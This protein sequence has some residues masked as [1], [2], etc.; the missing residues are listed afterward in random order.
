MRRDKPAPAACAAPVA[1]AERRPRVRRRIAAGPPGRCAHAACDAGDRGEAMNRLR[2]H[3]APLAPTRSSTLNLPPVR[4]GLLTKLNL[5]TVGLIF[6]TAVAIT[7]FYLWQQWRVDDERAARAGLDA[8]RD[9][10]RARRVRPLP[11]NDRAYLDAD[12]RQP[13]RRGRHRLR[14]RARRAAAHDRRAALRRRAAGRRRCPTPP[15]GTAMP[16]PATIDAADRDDRRPAL[17]RA[18]GARRQR[19]SAR[20]D[21]PAAR[22]GATTRSARRGPRS[23]R[24]DR[25]RPRSA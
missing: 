21:R 22:S 18:R 23:E 17:H 20:P 6:L 4:M 12:P 10:G 9:A 24:A 19:R 13:R 2:R 14:A 25:L 16:A 1:D 8:A 15:R 11:T 3:L 5:L 7:G